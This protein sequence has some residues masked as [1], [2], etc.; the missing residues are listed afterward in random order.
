MAPVTLGAV[1][2]HFGRDLDRGVSKVVGIIESAARDG[3]DMLVLPDACLGGYIGD[4]F[5]PRPR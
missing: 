1:A 5:C 2:G 3:V 4:F